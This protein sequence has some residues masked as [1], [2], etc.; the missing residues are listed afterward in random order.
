MEKIKWGIIGPGSIANNFADGLSGSYSGQLVGIASKNDER[1]KSFAD[2]YSVHEDFRFETYDDIINSEHIDAIYI[3]TPH[4]L[5][6]EW[7][8]KAAGKGK[9]VLCEKPGAVNFQE[10]KKVIEAVDEAGVFYMEGFMYRCHP[11]IPKLIE[12]IKNK[13]IGDIISV[14]SSFGFDMGK[15]IPDHRLFNKDLAGGGILDVGLYP[16]SFSRLVAGAAT[17]DKFL[18]PEILN[19]DGKI[20]ETGVD[21]IAHANLKFKNGVEAKVSTAIMMNMKNNATII[22]TKGVIELPDPWMPGKDGGPYH[23]KI[24]IKQ[25]NEEEIIDIKGPEHLFFFEAELA[26]QSI[27]KEKVQ[28]PHP[29]MNWEDTLGNLKALD[30]WRSKVNYKLPQ[31]EL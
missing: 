5:H 9:H 8:I 10:G 6:A 14:E 17:G 19:A 13:T 12:L 22:G 25:N 28:A 21:E 1:R 26:S 20:G 11:E 29:A 31:D 30:E 4:T 2:K 24:F 23:A 15:T 3:S 18:E 27:A 16:V 7:T